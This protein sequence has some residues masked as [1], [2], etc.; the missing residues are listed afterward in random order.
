MARRSAG[1]VPGL[2]WRS[3]NHY[4]RRVGDIGVNIVALL[5]RLTLYLLLLSRLLNNRIYGGFLITQRLGKSGIATVIFSFKSH[6]F[7]IRRVFISSVDS[8]ECHKFK[9]E[10]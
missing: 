10:K 5:V 3:W 1:R 9:E 4:Y 8:F 6:Q 7:Q 2:L